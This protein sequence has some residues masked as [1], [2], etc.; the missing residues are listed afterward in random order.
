MK[1]V[2]PRMGTGGLVLLLL[3]L[4]TFSPFKARPLPHDI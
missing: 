4:V 1:E 3:V 2:A